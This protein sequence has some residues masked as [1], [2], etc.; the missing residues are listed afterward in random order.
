VKPYTNKISLVQNGRGVYC[1]DTT[2][3]CASGMAA[4]VGGCYNDCYAAKTA[5]RYGHDFNK[6]VLRSFTSERHKRQ[7]LNQI[8]KIKMPFIRIGASGDPSENWDH[9]I[10]ILKVLSK[11]NTEIIIITR[12]W[13]LLTDRQLQYLSNLNICINTSVSALDNSEMLNRSVEQ[14]ERIK[15]FC[16]SVLRIISCN[17]NLQ[18]VTGRKL[19]GVQEDLFKNRSVLDTVF[20]PSKNNQFVLDGIIKVKEEIFNGKKCL[21]S[22]YNRK[23]YMGKCNVCKEMCG[24]NIDTDHTY[25]NKRGLTKQRKLF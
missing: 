4:N 23:T 14:Y 16:K 12:H 20:R 5:K 9:T 21:A 8:T 24:V 17:F 18:N 3:G 15:P 2:M 10:D 19:F 11:C 13:T 7:I 22:K 25:L 6:T 1:I